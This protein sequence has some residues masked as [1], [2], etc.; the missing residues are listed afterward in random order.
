MKIDMSAGPSNLK[1]PSAGRDEWVC[2][3]CHHVAMPHLHTG[4]GD[5]FIS[6]LLWL[7]AKPLG[8]YYDVKR[9]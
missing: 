6:L 4:F 7:I 2:S 9:Q 8:L 3:N 5:F 1:K